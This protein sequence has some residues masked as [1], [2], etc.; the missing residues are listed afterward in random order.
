MDLDSQKKETIPYPICSVVAAF[1]MRTS[2][3]NTATTEQMGYG[4]VSFFVLFFR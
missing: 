1:K 4:I 2:I 3:L